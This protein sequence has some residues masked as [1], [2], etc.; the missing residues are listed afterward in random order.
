MLILPFIGPWWRVEVGEALSLVLSPF[1]YNLT[2]LGVSFTVPLF[3]YLL[4]AI[5]VLFVLGGAM[6]IAG[7]LG[8][9]R[10]WGEQ[11][12]KFGYRKGFWIPV[13]FVITLL[14]GPFIFNNFLSETVTEGGV[15]PASLNVEQLEVPYLVGSSV[16]KA[17]LENVTVSAPVEMSVTPVFFFA[18]LTAVLSLVTVR[19]GGS[20]RTSSQK[21]LE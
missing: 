14:L 5:Q 1:H 8:R 16:F 9:G 17:S 19:Y 18:L 3:R 4:P 2:F 11:T 12:V 13:L 6:M 7:S 10:W 21:T 15:G 20:D